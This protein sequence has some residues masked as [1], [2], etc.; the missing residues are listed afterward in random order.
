MLNGKLSL[1]TGAAS[2]IGFAVAK[3]F[4]ENDSE[5]IMVDINEEVNNL[6]SELK[7][8]NDP[9]KFHSA[10]KCDVSKVDQIHSL[11]KSIKEKYP[12]FKVANVIV[13][14]AGIGN[15]NSFLDVTESDYDKTMSSCYSI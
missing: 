14:S 2:G 15:M 3:L 1:I 13:N 11:F 5:V 7:K 4:A 9:K 10:F 12:N 8:P 6:V